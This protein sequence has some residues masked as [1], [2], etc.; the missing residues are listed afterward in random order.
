M[1]ANLR[2]V[3]RMFSVICRKRDLVAHFGGPASDRLSNVPRTDDAEFH[4]SI[5]LKFSLISHARNE[6]V[7]RRTGLG[8]ALSFQKHSLNPIAAR[9]CGQKRKSTCSLIVIVQARKSS[10]KKNWILQSQVLMM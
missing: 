4:G 3:F 2:G 6:T 5:S 1:A 10:S 9:I 8:I 7:M